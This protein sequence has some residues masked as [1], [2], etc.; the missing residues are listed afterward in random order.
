MATPLAIIILAAGNSTRLKS[1]LTK[2]LHP[3]A[4][5]P[6]IDYVLKASR[7]LRPQE[8]VLV[9]GNDREKIIEHLKDQKDLSYAHQQERL[10]TA[11]ATQIALQ[12]LKMKQGQVLILSGDVPGLRVSTLKRLL[13]FQPQSPLALVTAVLSEPYG[14]G[15]ILRDAA[16][17]FYGIVEEKNADAGQKL[18]NEIN[19][20]IYRAEINFLRQALAQV[21]KDPIKKEYYLTDIVALAHAAEQ[22]VPTIQVEES[23]EILGAN[24]RA[25]LAYLNTLFREEIVRRHLAQGV[26]M[27]APDSVWIDAE[28]K[29]GAD[30]FLE[31]NVYLRGKTQMGSACRIESGCVLRDVQLSSE[32]HLRAYSHLEDCKVASK[33][34]IGPFARIRP[35]SRIAEEAHVGNFVELKKTQLGPGSKANH[36]SYLGD[37]KIGRKV[38]IGA[39]TITCNYDGKNKYPTTIADEVFIGSDTQLVAPVKLGQGAYVGAGTTVTKNVPAKALA[40]SRT[41]QKNLPN[42]IKKRK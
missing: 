34:V 20:G 14:Y 28:V 15:R 13:K 18:L 41:A 42:Y 4:G 22:S 10:G 26:G 12:K 32:V 21:K 31:P 7:A 25:E 38:N 29:I 3:I 37:A 30:T 16:G 36:L 5:L 39:G 2:V 33:A 1:R 8:I 11:H 6:M 35:G 40:I 23:I 19:T 9:L 24:T 27:E 17:D